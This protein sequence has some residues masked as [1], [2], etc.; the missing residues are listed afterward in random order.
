MGENELVQTSE[1]FLND[2]RVEYATKSIMSVPIAELSTLGAGVASLIPQLNT[3]TQTK[4]VDASGLYTL[5]N[6]E[7]GDTLKKAK[8]GTYWG[9]F[10]RADGSSKM[11]K[12][13]SAQQRQL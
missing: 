1:N 3:I 8:D 2:V 6:A 9:S 12:V 5:A 7:A 13:Q 10:K 11:L 4:V